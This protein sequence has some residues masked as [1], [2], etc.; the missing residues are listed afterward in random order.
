MGADDGDTAPMFPIE[1]PGQG[2]AGTRES[3]RP[4]TLEFP[5]EGPGPRQDQGVNTPAVKHTI[6]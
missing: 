5:S 3:L 6:T 2:P 1:N 4:S